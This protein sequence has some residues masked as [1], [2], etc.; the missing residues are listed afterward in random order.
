MAIGVGCADRVLA[1][2]EA[3]DVFA[4]GI[5]AIEP[6]RKRILVIIPDGT[7]SA[8]VPLCF[9][10]L[11]DLMLPQAAKVDFV[12]AV[13][14]HPKMSE[15]DILRHVGLTPAERRGRYA[16]VG[17]Y[18]HDWSSGLRHIGTLSAGEMGELSEGLWQRQ[19]PVMINERIFD[20]DHILICGPVFPHAVVGYSG[21]NKYFFPGISGP[22][23]TNV[24]HWLAGLIG[25]LGIIGHR[26]TPT[27][28]M[29][30]RA[31]SFIDLPKSC[32]SLVVQGASD[33]MGLYYGSPED[34]QARA[35]EL[36]AQ[37]NVRYVDKQYETVVAV[38]PEIYDDFW[39]GCKGMLKSEPVVAD[40]GTL[41]IYAPHINEISYTHGEALE[42]V[43]YHVRD[44]YLAQ[45]DELRD[46]DYVALG[47][48]ALTRGAGT[49]V[50]GVESFRVKLI[51]A[52]GISEERCLGANLGYMNHKE[53]NLQDWV[54]R[55]DEGVLVIPRAGE[56]LYCVRG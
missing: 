41:I 2:W 47:H 40:G 27:R 32:Y 9:R 15:S 21:G 54:G 5:A 1:K 31:A 12:I 50:D 49:Y 26:D 14:T 28:R 22:H 18:N 23:V 34:S 19:V 4:A 52:T 48:A 30:D 42:R 13:G 3:R 25:N 56:M 35:V 51:L 7:R 24:T 8:P 6:A 17:I 45:W 53:L 36:S 16:K 11:T 38:V 29:L 33:L 20:Y 37:V 39:T 10:L 55:E 43:G 46:I 44:Y